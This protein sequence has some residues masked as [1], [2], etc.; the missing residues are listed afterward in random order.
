LDEIKHHLF[1][2]KSIHE[3]LVGQIH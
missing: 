3:M 2:N 1:V